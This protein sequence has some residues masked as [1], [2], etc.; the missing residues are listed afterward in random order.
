MT[1]KFIETPQGLINANVIGLAQYHAE[2][3]VVI[4]NKVGDLVKYIQEDDYT[5]CKSLMGSIKEQMLNISNLDGFIPLPDNGLLHE[6]LVSST[7][8]A[9]DVNLVINDIN[10]NI[11]VWVDCQN[12]VIATKV[13]DTVNTAL[14]SKSKGLSTIDWDV[15]LK[16]DVKSEVKEEVKSG[17]PIL[18]LKNV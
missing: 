10:Q 8:I 11:I 15:L 14:I 16:E 18:D 4:S 7:S 2:K 1:K 3:G 9:N 13:L 6:S 17:K 5:E 12:P